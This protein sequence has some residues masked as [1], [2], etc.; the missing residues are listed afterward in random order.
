MYKYKALL[1]IKLTLVLVLGYVVIRTLLMQKHI[2]EIH[3]PNSAVG[4]KN[5]TDVETASSPH[6]SFQDYSL[7]AKQDIFGNSATSLNIDKPSQDDNGTSQVI[8]T[9]EE[10]GIA[11]LGTVAGDPEISR[12]II[13][14]L[15][16]NVLSLCKTGDKVATASIESIEKD[17]VVLIHHG[18]KKVLNLGNREYNS[19]DTDNTKTALAKKATRVVESNPPVKSHTTFIDNLRNTAIMLPK[20]V[21][22]PYAINDQV[23]GLK[24]TGLENIKEAG[25]IGLK[26]G[27]VIRT[28][29][30]HRL[31]DKQKAYQISMKART[32]ATLN[33]ELLRNNNIKT[34]S[35][36]LR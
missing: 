27:D 13:K 4:T 1:I 23:E 36:S 32:Q 24:I 28:V 15:E 26:N 10:L 35:F 30:G 12:A 3:M 31:V 25:N 9:E 11:L 22:K 6:T 2:S 7:I 34:F 19:H 17:A 20:A 16:S 33:V 29:N 18:Q 14:D 21:I 8:S 5:I